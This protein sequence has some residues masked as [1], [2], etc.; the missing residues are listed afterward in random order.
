M[1]TR[2]VYKSL[3]GNR[4]LSDLYGCEVDLS[5]YLRR[6]GFSEV[7][8]Q[9]ISKNCRKETLSAFGTS[10][11]TFFVMKH[12]GERL[13]EII[14]KRY[15]L[16]VQAHENMRT[17]GE[18]FG[19]SSE[20]VRQLIE[21][22][23]IIL[24]TPNAKT[25]LENDIRNQLTVVLKTNPVRAESKE[26]P[27]IEFPN[28]EDYFEE[29]SVFVPDPSRKEEEKRKTLTEIRKKFPRAYEPWTKEE[30]RRLEELYQRGIPT[31]ELAAFFQRKP[32]AINSRIKKIDQRNSKS[33]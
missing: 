32:G 2:S 30:D 17:I 19:I 15:G 22:A 14:A 12:D 6:L 16:G 18:E 9:H 7:Q 24:R 31:K 11:H 28:V 20:R 1:E 4:L 8:N 5:S 23:L 10:I 25:F 21:K 13:S 26:E 27:E 33:D 3:S 29:G